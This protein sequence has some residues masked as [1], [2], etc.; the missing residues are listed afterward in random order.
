MAAVIRI[1]V[2]GCHD[3]HKSHTGNNGNHKYAKENMDAAFR[4]NAGF[5]K[6]R[7]GGSGF[8]HARLSTSLFVF[9]KNKQNPEIMA[10]ISPTQAAL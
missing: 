1:R 5:W 10:A 2:Y 8:L 7:F 9:A 4:V 6:Y 3:F